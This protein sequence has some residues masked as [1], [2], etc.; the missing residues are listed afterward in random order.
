MDNKEILKELIDRFGSNQPMINFC[1]IVSAL[2]DIKHTAAKTESTKNEYDYDRN[3]WH[4]AAQQLAN[5][6]EINRIIK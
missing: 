2:Y 5:D 1:E 6:N 4:D 3:W